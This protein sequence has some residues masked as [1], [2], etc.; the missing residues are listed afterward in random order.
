MTLRSLPRSSSL[1]FLIFG[2]LAFAVYGNTPALAQGMV[3]LVIR[4]VEVEPTKANGEA[5][6]AFN[7]KPDLM[8]TVISGRKRFTSSVVMNVF[9]HDFNVKALRVRA[10]AVVEIVVA[11]QD[12]AVDDEIGTLTAVISPADI[13]KGSVTFSGFGRVKQLVVEFRK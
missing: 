13:A 6:D 10:G 4:Q 9:E 12:I 7:G 8:V 3:D 11:D 5:W 1:A 2:L